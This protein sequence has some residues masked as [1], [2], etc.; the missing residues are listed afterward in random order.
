[1]MLARFLMRVLAAYAVVGSG[2]VRAQESLVNYKS[3]SPAMAL[4]L[5]QAAHKLSATRI[6]GGNRGGR[7]LRRGPGRVA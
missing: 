2:Q 5:A 4:E 1:M 7:S 6:P 3:L